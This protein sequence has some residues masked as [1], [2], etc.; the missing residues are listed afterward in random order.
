M[1]GALIF[2]VVGLAVLVAVLVA[3]PMVERY[4]RQLDGAKLG[5][6][7]LD[8]TM[9]YGQLRSVLG[10]GKVDEHDTVR[11]S[12]L[13][14]WRR[15]LISACFL[16]RGLTRD[17]PDDWAVPISFEIAPGFKGS[18]H[19]LRITDRA[20]GTPQRFGPWEICVYKGGGI[21]ARDTSYRIVTEHLK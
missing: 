10:S 8:Y 6:V 4:Q 9:H 18:F 2:V 13:I 21:L 5:D 14:T 12:T 19:G 15:G 20:D 7:S 1:R 16:G 3:I 11:N 17:L